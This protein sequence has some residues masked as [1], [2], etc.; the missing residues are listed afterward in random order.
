MKDD[1]LGDYEDEL[2]NLDYSDEDEEKDKKIEKVEKK[3]EEEEIDFDSGEISLKDEDVSSL[4]EEDKKEEEEIDSKLFSGQQIAD[5]KIKINEDELFRGNKVI[6]ALVKTHSVNVERYK[7]KEE[8]SSEEQDEAIVDR[9]KYMVNALGLVDDKFCDEYKRMFGDIDDLP[10]GL[11]M[12]RIEKF[13]P[14]KIPIHHLG[15]FYTKETYLILNIK[16]ES[17]GGKEVNLHMWLGKETT[18]DKR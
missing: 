3:K 5:R 8:E 17:R 12:W 2:K 14:V 18:M 16:E 1:D 6:E 4:S 11:K 10:K 7:A 13:L 15:R 9:P